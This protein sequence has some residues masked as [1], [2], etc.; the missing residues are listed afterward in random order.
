MLS[1]WLPLCRLW[2][3]CWTKCFVDRN[4][5]AC[6]YKTCCIAS[7]HAWL[8][9]NHMAAE[10][11]A[12]QW[13]CAETCPIAGRAYGVSFLDFRFLATT[14]L[15]AVDPGDCEIQRCF[16]SSAWIQ[17]DFESASRTHI[18]CSS[19]EAS[20]A[21]CKACIGQYSFLSLRC[22]Q[23]CIHALL[24]LALR[25]TWLTQCCLGLRKQRTLP[26]FYPWFHSIPRA[27]YAFKVRGPTQV[28]REDL[29]VWL[30]CL[31]LLMCA[32]NNF[33]E[34]NRVEIC[35]YVRFCHCTATHVALWA[36]IKGTSSACFNVCAAHLPIGCIKCTGAFSTA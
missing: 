32:C 36:L 31:L 24:L 20:L 8:E 6:H 15:T 7:S 14:F 35:T 27:V 3:H 30:L 2:T 33:S 9:W 16:K 18:L 34:R 19:S 1:T 26:P 11:G 25:Q 22:L 13:I 23:C 29:T 28:N 10:E 12:Q 21:C 5:L 17:V 4:F